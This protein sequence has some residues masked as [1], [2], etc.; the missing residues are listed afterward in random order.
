MFLIIFNQGIRKKTIHSMT[1]EHVKKFVA[2]S[3]GI[4]NQLDY[5][6]KD[7]DKVWGVAIVYHPL[8]IK[9]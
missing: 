3:G 9:N 8:L 5:R 7:K 1:D 6:S 4:E 2:Y